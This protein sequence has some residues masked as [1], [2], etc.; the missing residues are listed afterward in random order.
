MEW[1][2]WIS[3]LLYLIIGEAI[4][5]KWRTTR[6]KRLEIT[7]IINRSI[8]SK[9]NYYTSRKKVENRTAI[10]EIGIFFFWPLFLIYQILFLIYI[11]IYNFLH[12]EVM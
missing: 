6:E 1:I 5:R 7:K 4:A 3:L 11:I 10:Q 8:I 12:K 2:F 9:N